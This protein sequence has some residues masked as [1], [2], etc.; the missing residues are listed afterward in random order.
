[1]IQ[2]IINKLLERRHFWRYATFSEI[3]ELYTAKTVRVIALNIISGFT[4]VYLYREGYSLTFIMSFWTIFYLLKTPVIIL[5]SMIVAHFGPK[6]GMLYGNLLY[7]PAMMALGSVNEFGVG[8]IIVWAIFVAF[9]ASL[10]ELGY[11]VNFSKIKNAE[12]AGREL[13]F[14]NI[15]IKVATGVSPV[16][17]GLLALWLGLEAV[18]WI[19][20]ALFL[21]ASIPLFRTAEQ[22]ETRQRFN[23]SGFPWRANIRNL[24]ANLGVGYDAIATGTVWPLF[25][26]IVIFSAY[27]VDIYAQLGLMSS[28]TIITALIA[29]YSYGKVIDKNRGGE[30]LKIS[31]GFNGLVHLMRVF[32]NSSPGVIATN[33]ANEVATAGHNMAFMRGSFDAADLSGHR[34]LYLCLVDVMIS[35]GAAIASATLLVLIL[36]MGHESG[37]TVFFIIASLAVLQIGTANFRLYRKKLFDSVLY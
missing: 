15:F 31:V 21:V 35:L 3:A 25:L 2:S 16:I 23:V 36:L 24:T 4:S 22:V 18:M 17:G 8:A 29:S 26:A 33:I 5:S 34:I 9:S 1:M 30:L 20:A 19:A 11:S 13:A 27:G 12:H 7:V 6:H 14:M 32:V 10:H 28:V 37:F